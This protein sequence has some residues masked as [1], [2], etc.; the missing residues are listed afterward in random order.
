MSTRTGRLTPVGTDH[1][2]KALV[3]AWRNEAGQITQDIGTQ[4][5]AARAT[6]LLD[7]AAALDKELDSIHAIIRS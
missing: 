2:L 4:Y 5:S 1:P 7:C 6:A 3:I